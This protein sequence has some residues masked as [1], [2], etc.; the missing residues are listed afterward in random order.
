MTFDG[1][2]AIFDAGVFFDNKGIIRNGIHMRINAQGVEAEI[3]KEFRNGQK[4]K[5]ILGH[6]RTPIPNACVAH[7]R[8]TRTNPGLN[9]HNDVAIGVGNITIVSSYTIRSVSRFPVHG[10]Y[11]VFFV[12]I[13]IHRYNIPL[14]IIVNQLIFITSW[15]SRVKFDVNVCGSWLYCWKT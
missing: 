14:Y 8:E 4:Q 15:N 3:A 10:V 9:L 6:G 5:Q 1:K 13:T 12:A 11:T 7:Y 2:L